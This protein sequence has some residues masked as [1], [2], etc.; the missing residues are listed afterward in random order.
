[1][2]SKQVGLCDG[3][4]WLN[5]DVVMGLNEGKEAALVYE[6]LHNGK[7]FV[8][9]IE[10]RIVRGPVFYK[11]EGRNS[12]VSMDMPPGLKGELFIEGRTYYL[13]VMKRVW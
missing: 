1:M 12:E 10:G 5:Y 9:V 8:D 3:T 2:S 13:S 4:A 7:K 6:S 11:I